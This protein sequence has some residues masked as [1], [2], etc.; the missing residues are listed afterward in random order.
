MKNDDILK[1]K[2]TKIAIYIRVGFKDDNEVEKQ[3]ELLANHVDKELKEK[4]TDIKYYIDNG[5]SGNDLNRKQLNKLIDDYKKNRIDYIYTKDL[6][7]IARDFSV[8]E[9]LNEKGLLVNQIKSINGEFNFD[10]SIFD[11]YKKHIDEAKKKFLKERHRKNE[12]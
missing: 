10:N 9:K 6:A 8:L 7:R 2:K 4:P 3:K 5:A 11:K 1:S 12:R